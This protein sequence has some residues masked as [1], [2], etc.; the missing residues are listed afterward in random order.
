M[1]N[2]RLMLLGGALAGLAMALVGGIWLAA[3]NVALGTF[4]FAL[5]LMLGPF[6]GVA[7]LVLSLIHI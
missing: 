4:F 7:L 2:T 6:L 5:A 1:T 3:T